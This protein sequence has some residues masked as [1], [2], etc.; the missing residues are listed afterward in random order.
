MTQTIS[1]KSIKARK[2]YRKL[3]N[4]D[5]ISI[6]IKAF[7]ILQQLLN[8]NPYLEELMHDA[9]SREEAIESI[10]SW[11]MNYFESNP[12]AFKYYKGEENGR[13]A[14]KNLSWR[15]YAAI[16]LMDY[17]DYS[18]EKFEDPNLKIR[19]ETINDPI[20]LLWLAIK[21]GTGGAKPAFFE[22]MLHLFRQFQ[23]LSKQNLPAEETVKEWISRHPSGLDPQIVRIREKNRDR[24]L[25]IFIKRIDKGEIKDKKYF[26]EE[27]LSQEEKLNTMRKWWN[28][29]LFHLRFAI[30]TTEL[31]NEMLEFSLSPEQ[32]DM[33][34]DAQLNGIPIFI[35]P[36]YLSL[37]NT[38]IHGFAAESDRTIRDYI[39][40]NKPL[41]NE[42]GKISAWEKED[43]I[44]DGKPNVAG[45]ILP[46]GH[47]V[48]RRYP[49][50][51]ILIPDT[52]GRACGGLCV[53]CQ[54][55]FDFQNGH[56][57]FDLERLK[58]EKPW[59]D[60]LEDIMKYYEEDSQLRDILITGGDSLMSSDKSLKRILDAVYEMAKNKIE[61]NKKR[62]DG[63]KFAEFQRIRLGTRMPV[64]L[65][66][67]IT[68]ELI[69]I[70]TEFK[71]KASLIGFKQF[72]IQTHFESA[73]EITPA[74][75]KAIEGL[76]SAGWIVTNQ[77][78][79]TA[80]ASRRGHTAKLRQA[81][82]KIGV[83]PYYTFSVKGFLE[84]SHNFATNA[85][86]VQEQIEEK[87]LGFIPKD[88]YQYIKTLPLDAENIVENIEK[89][90]KELNVPFL[91]T[92]RNVLNL[93]GVGK[94]L[95]YRVIGITRYGKRILEFDHDHTRS[96]SPIIEKM[97]KVIIIESKSITDF[98]KQLEE[99]GEDITEY[100]SIYGYSIGETERRMPI[101]EYPDYDYKVTE[102]ITNF[103]ML[104]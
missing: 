33:L 73:M 1:E 93:P 59:W 16:R 23:G 5:K 32:I 46:N 88:Y 9:Q 19:K 18:G 92:D 60:R 21:F 99:M 55:M 54:R 83:I 49:E 89:L 41:I 102:E 36:Y 75:K 42:F 85:R 79:F 100:E 44:E 94:S 11:V 14:L 104:E 67:R 26:F 66:Q 98:L 86:A 28:E 34:R 97:G 3:V 72:V 22:D 47:N 62:K 51:A 56:L 87:R 103:E 12:N 13:K 90:R 7:R 101:Y 61:A 58:P 17:V 40:I 57:N 76:L 74:V 81:L 31:L 43:I 91:A 82:N 20:K 68:P 15:D 48:H 95:T 77:L 27:G 37:L 71:H 38:R 80:A 70:L 53:S 30:R 10:R 39:M 35:N 45:F 4:L 29:S 78:V 50:V 64:Y 25:K 2:S 8:E 65:P 52:V 63:N 6:S 24:I 96:H 84:N 69:E